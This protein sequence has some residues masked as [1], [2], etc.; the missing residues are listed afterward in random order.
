[1]CFA[2]GGGYLLNYAIDGW[3]QGT[4]SITGKS[5]R[6]HTSTRTGDHWLL[7]YV[8]VSCSLIAG[9]ALALLAI[10]GFAASLRRQGD[11]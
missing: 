3:D 2:Y 7:F 1:M 4:I 9:A 11:E 8:W 6:I 10:Y 5:G